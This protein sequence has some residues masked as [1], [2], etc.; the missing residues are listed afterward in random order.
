MESINIDDFARQLIADK[1]SALI[2]SHSMVSPKNM[3]IL[4]V[5]REEYFKN[6]NQK[7][8]ENIK[9]LFNYT[10]YIDDSIDYKDF[11][12][13]MMI[14]ALKFG[15]NK[16]KAMFK[17]HQTILEVALRRLDAIDPDL[18]NSHSAL[19]QHYNECFENLDSPKKDEHH[20]VTFGKEIATKIFIE[21][22]DLYS[23]TNNNKSPLELNYRTKIDD[24]PTPALLE[25]AIKSRKRKLTQVANYKI[26]TPLFQL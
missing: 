16:G 20:L 1:C 22:I 4:K 25:T 3:E 24:D 15:L 17:D 19:L 14:I 8:Y 10:K 9:K 13:R 23:N 7:N 12:R 21:T 26:A 2:E 11:S 6:P 18:R 5:V